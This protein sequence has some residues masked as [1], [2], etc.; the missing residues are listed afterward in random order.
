M[1]FNT[2][3]LDSEHERYQH[4]WF[5]DSE[6]VRNPLSFENKA[7]S[8][9]SNSGR[10]NNIKAEQFAQQQLEQQKKKSTSV[11]LW[12]YLEDQSRKFTL[13]NSFTYHPNISKV[14]STVYIALTIIFGFIYFSF[15]SIYRP[16]KNSRMLKFTEYSLI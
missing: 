9:K 7:S 11:S 16:F 12:D 14:N 3:F 10:Q 4:G 2:F 6:I 15:F 1:R 8:T 13:F 5:P